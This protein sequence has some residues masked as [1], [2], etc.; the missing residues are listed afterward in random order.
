MRAWLL[1]PLCLLAPAGAVLYSSNVQQNSANLTFREAGT[2]QALRS[3]FLSEDRVLDL[4]VHTR[5]PQLLR[6]FAGIGRSLDDNLTAAGR[7]SSD[8]AAETRAIKGQHA[9]RQAWLAVARRDVANVRAKRPQQPANLRKRDLLIDRFTALNATYQARLA[10]VRKAEQRTAELIPVWI[11][12]ALSALFT[13]SAAALIVRS[14]RRDARRA[15]EDD[16]AAAAEDSFVASQ[17]R[18]SEALQVAEDQR[19]AHSLM[20]RH[21]EGAI[22]GAHAVVLNR[23]NS[24]DRLEP[25]VPLAD[26]DPLQLPLEQARPRSCLALRLSRPYERD[27]TSAELLECEICGALPNASSCQ[28]LLVGGEVIGS[29][30]VSSD[31]RQSKAERRRV[32][33]SVTQAA[34][35]LANLRNL[36]IAETRAA[37]D[38]LTGL[39][40]KRAMDESIKRMAAQ[41]GRSGNAMSVVSL[42][43]DHFKRINDTYGHDRGDETLAAVSAL[44]RAE[45]R[46]SDLAGRMGGEE[47]LIVLPDTGRPGALRLAEK[48]RRAMHGIKVSGLEWPITASMGVATLPD[49]AAEI[50]ALLRIADRALYAAKRGGR[51]RVEAPSSGADREP[52]PAFPPIAA[53]DPIEPLAPRGA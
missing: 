4:Y 35:I 53:S 20:R 17:V 42:D 48:I 49:D 18:F 15:R 44:L 26:D 8:D 32:D 31:R 36:A 34:P 47:F 40:N 19:E 38:A 43:L 12:L 5:D 37:T 11:V 41:A 2:A 9:L 21:L 39:P 51:D 13:G 24:G 10:V 6:R 45:L 16:A 22:P 52:E 14:R 50:D 46:A 28:P 29:V 23:N 3:E 25:S 1:V 33:D 7:A 30:L 27:G